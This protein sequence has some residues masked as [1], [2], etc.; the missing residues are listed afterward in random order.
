MY[1]ASYITCDI[2]SLHNIYYCTCIITIFVIVIDL[3]L[4]PWPWDYRV[5]SR[6]PCTKLESNTK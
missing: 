6:L 3:H 5:C 4:I 1:V 2:L